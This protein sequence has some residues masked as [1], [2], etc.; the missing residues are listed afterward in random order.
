MLQTEAK[1]LLN[2]FHFK[3][4]L[5]FFE[6]ADPSYYTKIAGWSESSFSVGKLMKALEAFVEV[7]APAAEKAQEVM[8]AAD[9]NSLDELK[10]ERN[11][12]VRK[13]DYLRSD[14]KHLPTNEARLAHALQIK[15]ISRDIQQTWDDIN[16]LE[17]GKPIPDRIERT[18]VEEVFHGVTNPVKVEKIRK[19]YVSYLS[20]ARKGLRSPDLIP[21]YED[22]IRE[23]E[24]RVNESV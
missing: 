13:R 15:Q 2:H 19:N 21:F 3:D 6:R 14:L 22:V 18:E 9:R 16:R 4:A 11:Q 12:L 7:E 1:R 5:A 10:E 24:R 23:A 20:K 8:K 17:A